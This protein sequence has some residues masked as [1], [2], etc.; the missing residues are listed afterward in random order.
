M[1][2]PDY[3]RAR[4]EPQKG[5]RIAA[6]VAATARLYARL[7][8]EEITLAAVAREAGFT[9]SNLYRYFRNREEIFLE[10]LKHSL[11]S[12]RVDACGA[13]ARP[14]KTA[15]AFAARWADVV[16]AHQRLVEL[17]TLLFT[18]I[19]KRASLDPLVAFKRHAAAETEALA[20]HLHALFPAREPAGL[21]EFIH[22]QFALAV[23]MVPMMNLSAKQEEALR[24][25][26]TPA[27][28]AADRREL[29]V[30]AVEALAGG[31][32][33]GGS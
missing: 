28:C 9:R 29:Y 4:S 17:F 5:E 32:L 1:T 21:L 8:P 33:Y 25:A 13:L 24:L 7:E 16:L 11:T 20:S 10:L 30:R 14:P 15:R 6:L 19:E 18:T 27:A 2:P 3:A 12:W 31:M 22:A 23:G 26:G